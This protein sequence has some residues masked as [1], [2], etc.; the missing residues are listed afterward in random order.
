MAAG[1][2]FLFLVFSVSGESLDMDEAQTWDYARLATISEFWQELSNDPASE[3][4]MP[5]GMFAWWVWGRIAGTSEYAMRTLNLLWAAGTMGCFALL[6]RK[7]SMGWLPLLMAIQ[8]YLW[9]SMNHARTPVLQIATG[10]LLLYGIVR[11]FTE[12]QISERT[13]LIFVGG[14]VLLCGANM[15]GLIP[16]ISVVTGLVAQKIWIR[17]HFTKKA[18]VILFAGLGLLGVLGCYYLASLFRGAGGA[19]IWNVSP[20]NAIYVLYEFLGFQGLGPGRQDLRDVMRGFTPPSLMLFHIP[21][22][23][24]LVAGYLLTT[25]AA[26]KAWLTRPFERIAGSPSFLAVWAAGVGVLIQSLLML[27]LLAAVVGFPFWGRH[28][29]G[30]FPFWVI[31]L[32]LTVRW[33]GQG[34]WRRFGRIGAGITLSLLAL[35][36]ALLHW[37]PQHDH[38]D[39]RSAAREALQLARES[40]SIWWVA[41]HSGGS[42]YGITFL[43]SLTPTPGRISFAPNV[44][45]PPGPLPDVIIIS[46]P[47]NFDRFGAAMKL[48]RSGQYQRTNDFH[49]FEVWEKRKGGRM[50]DEGAG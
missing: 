32:A 18:T 16:V 11:F 44:A 36:S 6:G 28:L 30:A 40:R 3:A 22:I 2:G 47:D 9:Y 50:K 39:Y 13:L 24:A 7:L 25:G 26:C 43:E 37:A 15:L 21:V 35:S 34:L 5:L 45:S 41:D 14:A 12:K 8:P 42:Y 4:Q 1:M 46:R 19:K 33:A 29:A 10:S 38:D 49:A 27:F 48:I 23:L 20:I 17:I 31:T